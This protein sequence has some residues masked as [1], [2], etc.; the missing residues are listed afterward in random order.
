MRTRSISWL[1]V[2]ALAFA[3]GS[4][5]SARQLLPGNAIPLDVDTVDCSSLQEY[6]PTV[7]YGKGDEVKAEES[8]YGDLGR[9]RC[10]E[11]NKCHDHDPASHPD[12]WEL[13]GHCKR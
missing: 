12:T 3:G 7:Y 10:K 4:L 2:T 8:G 13:R 6:S 1:L 5:A 9:Y 11:N